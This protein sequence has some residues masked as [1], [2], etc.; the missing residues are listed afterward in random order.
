VLDDWQQSI[1]TIQE[2]IEFLKYPNLTEQ[3]I[4]HHLV[5]NSLKEYGII[6]SFIVHSTNRG[7]VKTSG[8]FGITK[9]YGSDWLEYPI[10]R[11]VPVT[12]AIKEN[13]IVWVNTLPYWSEEYRELQNFELD[14]R[15]KTFIAVPYS[16]LKYPK[17]VL[18]LFSDRELSP[19]P[20]FESL[21]QILSNLSGIKIDQDYEKRVDALI[22]NN[23]T[24]NLTRRQKQIVNLLMQENSNPEI[25]D[26]LGYSISTIK[27]EISKIYSELG[28]RNREDLIT[29]LS[30]FTSQLEKL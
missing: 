1:T 3:D 26:F 17:V 18:G 14:N 20:V 22:E 8:Q 13:K 4:C 16:S 25:A 11:K 19:S 30:G 10:D 2:F 7:T 24:K 28:V 29:Y 23:K 9:T 6:S 12:D 21:V 27:Q 15:S 5:T